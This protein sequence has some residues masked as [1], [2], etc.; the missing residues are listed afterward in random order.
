MPVLKGVRCPACKGRRLLV[1][2]VYHPTPGLTVRYRVCSDCLNRVVTEERVSP[3]RTTS[4]RSEPFKRPPP[5]GA[6]R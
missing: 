3:S 1:G 6:A 2:H 4:P 5:G